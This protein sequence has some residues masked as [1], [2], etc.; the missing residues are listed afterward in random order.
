MNPIRAARLVPLFFAAVPASSIGGDTHYECVIVSAETVTDAG[1]LEPH[2]S[3]AS[4]LGEKFTVDRVTGRTIGG[5]MDNARMNTEV[6][7]KGSS[8]VSKN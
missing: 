1:S 7:D 4:F 6:I 3:L 8:V 5:P 2:W